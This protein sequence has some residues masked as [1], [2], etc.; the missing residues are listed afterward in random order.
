MVIADALL[1]KVTVGMAMFLSVLRSDNAEVFVSEVVAQTN[2]LLDI[3]HI[4]S[5]AYHPQ[6]Q[7][8]VESMH[9][10]LN[11]VVRG[12]VEDQPEDW[13]RMIPFAECILRAQPMAVLGNRSPYEIV[14]GIKPKLLGAMLGE[15]PRKSV[16]V[17]KYVTRLQEYMRGT[18]R[19][20]Q[21]QQEAVIERMEGKEDG[22]LSAGLWP[23]YTVLVKREKFET[24][25]G[26]IRFKARVYRTCTKSQRKSLLTRSLF[27]M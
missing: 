15:L 19:L 26:P 5:S 14:T 2:R 4:R 3:K 17:G 24:K 6:S 10:T 22:R 11:T 21:R 27:R 20:V 16:S 1:T 8:R 25:E 23:G 9:K 18:Y 13:E 7:G 12:L